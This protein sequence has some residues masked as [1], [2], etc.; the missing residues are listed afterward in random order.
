MQSI[1]M[2]YED[3]HGFLCAASDFY[4]AVQYLIE[5][6]WLTDG[7]EFFDW[8]TGNTVPLKSFFPNYKE[9]ILN[10]WD[11]NKFNTFFCDDF[12]LEKVEIFTR[13]QVK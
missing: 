13:V 7:M 10:E 11:I 8:D 1:I 5:N 9:I 4:S 6:N 3:S 2:V 12:R